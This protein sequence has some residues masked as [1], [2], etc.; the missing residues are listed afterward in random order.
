MLAS[1]HCRFLI[2]QGLLSEL[3]E[4]VAG[5]QAD[6][7][8]KDQDSSSHQAAELHQTQDADAP[9]SAAVTSLAQHLQA[10]TLAQHLHVSDLRTQQQQQLNPL[11]ALPDTHDAT[12]AAGTRLKRSSSSLK[13]SPCQPR[14]HHISHSSA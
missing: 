5:L 14:A 8:P 2:Q 11:T 6:Q 3:R 7:P 10:A 4:L 9:R 12:H 13:L 1:L